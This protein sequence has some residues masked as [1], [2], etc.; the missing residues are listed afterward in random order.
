L[1]GIGKRFGGTVALE[2]IDWS[3]RRGEVHCLVGENGSGKSTLI[4]I[5]AG[6]HAPD[7][8]GR[9][10]IDGVAYASLSPH[11]AK[12]LGI[13]VIFQDLSL[14]PNLTVLENIAVDLELGGA[15]RAAPWRAM[16]SAAAAAI[17]RID[18]NLP[19]DAR[20]GTLP[21]AQR[22]L[23]AICRGLAVNARL[24]VMDEPTS[25]LTRQEVD[26]LLDN[27]RRLKSL[28][29]AVVFVSHRLDEV[30]EIA[31]RVTV[32]RDGRNVGTFPAADV[33]DHRL[34][35]LMTGNRI[36]H[37]IA[38]RPIDRR[39]PVLDVRGATRVGE[40]EDVTFALHQGEVL[41]LI[42][43]LGAGR[44]ELALA[45]F[46]MSRLDRGDLAVEGRRLSFASNQGAIAAGIAYVSEDRLSL[47]VNLRQSIADNISLAVV[48]RL[49]NRFGLV[50]PERRA[51]LATAWVGRLNIKAPRMAA[52]V[53]TLSGGN[54]QR[55]V[56]AKW[57]ATKPKVL[58]LDG[59]TVGVDVRNKQ[60]IYEVIHSLAR[61][62][63]A[64]LLISDEVSEVY[65][66]ADRV[67]H[68]RGGRIAG[69]FVPGTASEQAIAEA[70]YA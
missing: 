40:F 6:V 68:M 54:Q 11:Q 19:L 46:G 12:A 37:K 51:R 33:N 2:G 49:A 9:I 3:L 8:G 31:E 67:L 36:E 38:A 57:L 14:F 55:V 62:G 60:G 17:G 61:D 42:G 63:M 27:I 4:K 10:T 1:E 41:G 47:G 21:V 39:R 15:L 58:I 32:L 34:A 26:L 16:R 56:L 44:T 64:I 5:V 28:G 48:D 45:L 18:A 43:L 53:Q 65:Y 29:V 30:V 70:V 66:N 69:E 24:L 20:I 59:P 22:Q 7:P 25:S 50:A 23:V 35:E 52:A 13:Q